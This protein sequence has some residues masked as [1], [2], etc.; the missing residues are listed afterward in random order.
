MIEQDSLNSPTSSQLQRHSNLN[1]PAYPFAYSIMS[2][3]SSVVSSLFE[4]DDQYRWNEAQEP[5][6]KPL[7]LTSKRPAQHSEGINTRT[8]LSI[9]YFL[10]AR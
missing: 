8:P 5:T 3:L 10:K 7:D 9:P 4:T 2:Q 6:F 1:L